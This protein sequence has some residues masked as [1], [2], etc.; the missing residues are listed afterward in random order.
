MNARE[1]QMFKALKECVNFINGG[2]VLPTLTQEA[3][4]WI[5]DKNTLVQKLEARYKEEAR[6]KGRE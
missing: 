2:V 5:Q 3:I 6:F 4:K 1:A